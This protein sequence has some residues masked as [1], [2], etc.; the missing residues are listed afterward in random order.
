M[1]RSITLVLP[2]LIAWLAACGGLDAEGPPADEFA[3]TAGAGASSGA[4]PCEMLSDELIRKHFDVAP[5]GVTRTPS[6][7]SPH[8]FCTASWPRPNAAEIEKEQEDAMNEYV[9]KT[10]RGEDAE[11]PAVRKSVD[12]VVL[13]IRREVFENRQ[14]ALSTFDSALRLLAKG[15]KGET[16]SAAKE[17][18]T[19]RVVPVEGIGEKAAWL[20]E[21]Q[22]LSVATSDRIVN[23]E[24]HISAGPEAARQKAKA[25]ARDVTPHL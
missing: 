24:L 3:E 9:S 5:T 11:R 18:P 7:Y 19:Y 2:L 13:T 20:P 22:L 12:E 23:V 4:T 6:Q 15:R 1:N 10:M 17:T 14:E 25:V 16:G 8:P 21:K